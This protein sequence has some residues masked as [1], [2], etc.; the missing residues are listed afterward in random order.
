ME[1]FEGVEL[2][3]ASALR[4]GP[5]RLSLSLTGTLGSAYSATWPAVSTTGFRQTSGSSYPN[6]R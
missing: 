3:L 1:G 5:V 2:D 4:G 6:A